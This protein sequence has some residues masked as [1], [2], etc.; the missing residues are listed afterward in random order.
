[1]KYEIVGEPMPVVI[2]DLLANESMIT[3]SGSMVWMSPN[4]NM[5]TNA[6]GSLGR[7]FGRLF[8]GESIFQNIYT[9]Q[10]GP[11]MIAFASSFPGSIRAV[12]ITP[13]RPVVVQKSGFLASESGVELSVFFQKKLGT[14]FFGGE[15]F[16][17]QKL[18]GS[19][20]AFLEIDGSAV[21]YDLAPGQRL[22]V[23]TGNLAMMDATCS[24]DIQ[25]VKGVKN[26]LFGG[27]GLFLTVVTGPGKVILQTMPISGVAAALIPFLPTGNN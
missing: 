5:S 27:E 20:T 1:M 14:G 12:E 11:G 7:A 26:V 21:E 8:S 15:G 13:Q 10:G 22:V 4:M 25:S 3:E 24:I 9:A 16:I 23:D 2:C 18:S 19:G 6:G 17:M